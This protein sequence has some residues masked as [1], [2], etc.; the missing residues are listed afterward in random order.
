MDDTRFWSLIALID[1]TALHE[2][3]EDG[4]LAKL[5]DAVADLPRAELEGFEEVL[6]AKLYALDGRI[7]AVAAGDSGTSDDGFLYARCFVVAC[8][9]SHYE[10]VL[11]DPTQMPTSLDDWCEGLLYVASTAFEGQ[12][13]EDWSFSATLD[14][15]TGSNHRLWQ[16]PS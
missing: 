6:A 5:D 9:K 7:Y 1:L 11:A 16:K 15:E 13:D 8:G 4:A 2:G 14:Y 12:S 3:D 10:R